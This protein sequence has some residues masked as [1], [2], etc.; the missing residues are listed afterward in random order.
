MTKF[1]KETLADLLKKAIRRC[2]IKCS[3][4]KGANQRFCYGALH[5]YS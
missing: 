4:T 3:K 2:T 1:E 5:W